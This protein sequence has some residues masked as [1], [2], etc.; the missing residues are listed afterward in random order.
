MEIFL[1]LGFFWTM[2]GI[3]GLFGYQRIPERC[4]NQS[5]T[6]QYIRSSGISWMMLGIPWVLLY[7]ANLIWDF[8]PAHWVAVTGLA[9]VLSVPSIV[10]SLRM[11]AKYKLM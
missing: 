6:K 11:E 2:Y 9:L 4:K 10:Y 7:G 3:A 8:I 5:W 1:F